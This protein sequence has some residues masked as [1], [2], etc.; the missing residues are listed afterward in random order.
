MQLTRS[1]LASGI[2]PDRKLT[3]RE[4]RWIAELDT[5]PYVVIHAAQPERGWAESRYRVTG[6]ASA[7]V[8]AKSANRSVILTANEAAKLGRT[9]YFK[10]EE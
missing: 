8:V 5:T 6:Y 10:M 9:P 2:R 3:A 4:A 1:Q 7:R